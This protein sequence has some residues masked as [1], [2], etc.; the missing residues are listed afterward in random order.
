MKVLE[1]MRILIVEDD[2]TNM[3]VYQAILKRSGAHVIQDVRTTDVINY[4]LRSLPIDLILLD[5]MLRHQVNGYDIFDKVK[6][7]AELA[8]IPVIAVT[9]ADP[10]IELPKVKARG[11]AG[12]IG[13][14]IDMYEFP[15]Q[16][17]A[18]VRGDRLW[19]TH[20]GTL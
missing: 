20:L 3:A 8:N 6:G 19:V 15:E 18:C 5:L 4:M 14:P 1:G 10:D 16:I 13:K 11:F 17:A 7:I 9:A 2:P 12:F